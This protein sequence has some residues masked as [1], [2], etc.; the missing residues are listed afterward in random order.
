MKLRLLALVALQLGCSGSAT[1][2]TAPA[3]PEV[4]TPAASG[5]YFG[6]DDP[7][8]QGETLA[9]RPAAAEA[10]VPQRRPTVVVDLV[11]TG[12]DGLA[13]LDD[14]G[15]VALLDLT[16]QTRAYWSGAGSPP[17]TVAGAL[18]TAPAF[19]GALHSGEAWVPRVRGAEDATGSALVSPR[20]DRFVARGGA[21]RHGHVLLASFPEGALLASLPLE[22]ATSPELR[23]APSG[24][25]FVLCG[26]RG[27]ALHAAEDGALAGS[28]AAPEATTV[29]DCAFRPVGGALAVLLSDGAVAFLDTRSLAPHATAPSTNQGRPDR[30]AWSSDGSFVATWRRG[31]G[32]VVVH[33]AVR[34]AV[35]RTLA[36]DLHASSIAVAAGGRWLLL[37]SVEGEVLAYDLSSGTPRQLWEPGG[38]RAVV[39]IDPTGTR[40]AFV[41]GGD[42]RY[43]DLPAEA[44]VT[45]A[46][47]ARPT[48]RH[49]LVLGDDDRP[50][51]FIRAGGLF[52][53]GGDGLAP[54]ARHILA[55]EPLF[56]SDSA[57]WITNDGNVLDPDGRVLLPLPDERVVLEAR[58]GRTFLLRRNDTLVVRDSAG[59]ERA[60]LAL[61]TG[62]TVPCR[63]RGCPLPLA[64][65]P[66]G[67]RVAMLRDRHL[68]VFDTTSG[69]VVA[70][71][72]VGA[73]TTPAMFEIDRTGTWLRHF[74]GTGKLEI[75]AVDGLRTA[76]RAP[77]PGE[78]SAMAFSGDGRF[79]AH[80]EPGVLVI[81]ALP[82]RG[83]PR[84]VEAPGETE[85]LYAA[86]ERWLV[87][88]TR[89][90][91]TLFDAES[92]AL[93]ARVSAAATRLV[94]P[95]RASSAAAPGAEP[96]EPQ[97]TG[98]VELSVIECTDG[99][100]VLRSSASPLRSLGACTLA[101]DFTLVGP[102]HMAF[103]DVGAA[104]VVRLADG[105]S[106]RL[107]AFTS[108]G[109][110]RML[111]A[112]AADGHLEGTAAEERHY[113][114]RAAGPLLSAALTPAHA[115]ARTGLSAAFVAP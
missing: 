60:T 86:G 72:Q 28:Y 11:F 66:D 62:E 19:A 83:R 99:A 47:V 49:A 13:V 34:G 75:L 89:D 27:V 32:H 17:L 12:R 56:M 96:A 29:E 85:S 22:P 70:E 106:L 107:D 37:G 65:A 43:A 113:L 53:F 38:D 10:L 4:P 20:G 41:S 64:M 103:T 59:T 6:E 50:F 14:D 97:G 105:A 63:G 102:E 9:D 24:R 88:E 84:R 77:V 108:R 92:G 76:F 39:A 35:V 30:L 90:E 69:V 95:P 115:R 87:R 55:G 61:D 48:P 5:A 68:R 52:R 36:T 7:P 109:G 25:H 114:V 104:H 16:G 74:D 40:S 81:T 111:V 82:S 23:W 71:R 44:P 57:R 18:L 112:I 42:I 3:A 78:G 110:T 15:D 31:S 51:A 33:D 8:A 46:S 94:L 26:L 2:A 91:V 54:V 101:S 79:H 98:A 73:R 100:L 45:V 67:A 21:E 93:L 1:P 80:T 58:D